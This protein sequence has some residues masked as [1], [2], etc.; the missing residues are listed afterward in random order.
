LEGCAL[1]MRNIWNNN[2]ASA[3]PII[4]FVGGLLVSGLMYTVFFIMVAPSLFIF[5]PD[6]VYKTIIIYGFIWFLPMIILIVGVIA[7][8]ISAQKKNPDGVVYIE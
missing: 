3:I 7:L 4:L 6:S 1:K 5:I 8:L 2:E